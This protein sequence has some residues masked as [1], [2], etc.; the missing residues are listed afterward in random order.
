MLS[1]LSLLALVSASA[2]SATPAHRPELKLALEFEANQGQVAPEV[3]YLAR[4]SSHTVY[5]T[6]DG[7]T[8]DLNSGARRGAPLHIEL[9]GG[10]PQAVVTSDGRLPGVSNYFIGNDP[11]LWKRGVPHFAGVRYQAV[12]PGIDLLVH[13][14]D[15]S[16]EYDFAVSPDADP[17]AIRL[18]YANSSALRL[19]RDGNLIVET[20][21]GDVIQHV[22]EIYQESEGVR[23]PV[24]GRFQISAG[25][26]RFEIGAYDHRRT[27][28]IDPTVT[29][30]TYIGAGGNMSISTAA[31]DG[32]GNFYFSGTISSA[33]YPSVNAVQQFPT[34]AGLY[35]SSNQ[36]TTWNSGQSS[37]GSTEVFVLATDPTSPVTAYAGTSRG[38]F[39]TTGS[40]TG[41]TA[42]NSGMT[43]SA[44][45]SVAVDPL[46]PKT[47]YACQSASLYKSTDGGATWK[48]ILNGGCTAVAADP[49]AEGTIWV[50]SSFNYLLKSVDGG[51]NFSKIYHQVAVNAVAIDPTTSNNI[52]FAT[53][54]EGL[55]RSTDGGTT[56]NSI[57][58]GLALTSA[59]SVNINA[60]SVDRRNPSRVLLG[61]DTGV[62]VSSNSGFS[63]QTP[64]G[65]GIRKILSVLYDPTSDNIAL[66]GTAG[67]GVYQSI[68]GGQSWASV[69]PSNL[70]VRALAMSSDELT[71]Y[72]SVYNGVDAFVTRINPAGTG[73]VYSTFLGGTGTTRGNGMALDANGRIFLCGQT[74]AADYPMKNPYQPHIAGGTDF[75]ITRLSNDGSSLDASTYFGGHANDICSGLA[76]D[77]AGN[78]YLTGASILISTT[79][80]SDY[81]VTVGT[82]GPT[83][84]GGQDCVV[85]KFD[86]NLQTLIYSTFLGGNNTDSCSAIAVDSSGY[87]YVTGTTFSPNFPVTQGPF[88]GT[89]AAGSSTNVPAFVAKI[90]PDGSALLYSALLGGAK[91]STQISDITVDPTGRAY[92]TGFTTASDYPVTSGAL[93][94]ILPPQ[95]SKSVVTAVE[96][97]GSRLVYS[98]FL[99]GAGSDNAHFLALDANNTA[100]VTGQALDSLL[101]VTPDALPVTPAASAVQTPFL[102][103]LDSTGGTLLHATYLGGSAGGF[104]GPVAIGS[105]G[106]IFVTGTTLSTDFAVTGTPIQTSQTSDFYT[107]LMRLSFPASTGGGGGGGGNNG[108]TI[109]AVQNGASF[110]DGFPVNG[111]MTIKGTNLAPGTDTWA[112][113]IVNGLLPTTVDGVTVSVG[114]Q[115]AYVNYISPTQINVVA[116]NVAPGTVNISVTNSAGTSPLFASTAQT[117]Q[118]AF[119][120]AQ[121][122]VIATHLD[123]SYAASAH[124][125]DILI[126]WGTGFGPTNPPAP[127]GVAAPASSPTASLVTVMVGGMPAT[128]LYAVL[129]PGFA[130]LYQVAIQVP[131]PMPN[132]NYPVVAT[133]G[134]A[135]S[136][137][138]AILLVQ[139]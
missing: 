2:Y 50:G 24:H 53:N 63:F 80:S 91:G 72:A 89:L 52:F 122:Q 84:S 16:L 70:D 62:Y 123:F 73:V 10:D 98:T 55:L 111:W 67:G 58:A 131:S 86:N 65:I 116:P 17:S 135:S 35:R 132:G 104:A 14:R 121:G 56:F 106:S 126:L 71:T 7:L 33:D 85:S 3:L 133:V 9:A 100:W 28:V 25:E 18:R 115:L 112:N 77:T 138:S 54:Q 26:V 93:S 12:W 20:A 68:D 41:W 36:G 129:S 87:A 13:G 60:I 81:P 99:S 48:S 119:F 44:I 96:T 95:A 110:Q 108:P 114:G 136:P 47:L 137:T 57:T 92:V 27:L 19:D 34:N 46:S 125:G 66:A 15:Q 21:S 134:G 37:L 43:N 101:P 1:R 69:G 90:K 4:T 83:S 75:F 11:S 139:Q 117:F 113:F 45:L 124:P 105:G 103:A 6:R 39:K 61:T 59:S 40:G 22:P 97:D 49:K 102:A 127:V 30:S 79:I 74:D 130:A 38:L 31:A 64:T 8:L 5:L 128:V 23:E 107:Y 82:L 109:T 32:S 42:A 120:V 29:Y 118:P 78:V 51:G 76:L 94:K 88:G